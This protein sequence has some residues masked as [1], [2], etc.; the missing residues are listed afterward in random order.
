MATEKQLRDQT[1]EQVKKVHTIDRTPTWE[2]SLGALMAL[3]QSGN[4]EGRRVA[5]E[6]LLKL[7]RFADSEIARRKAI[8]KAEGK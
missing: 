7:A 6:E 3:M 5:S 2:S 1:E 8:A 4:A